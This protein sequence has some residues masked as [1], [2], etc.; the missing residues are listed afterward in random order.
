M[1]QLATGALRLPLGGMVCVVKHVSCC[2]HISRTVHAGANSKYVWE[3][4]AL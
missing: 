3:V 2:G 1:V 4:W